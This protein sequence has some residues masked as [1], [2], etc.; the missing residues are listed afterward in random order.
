[1]AQR[2]EFS[3]EQARIQ[4]GDLLDTVHARNVR[5]TITHRGFPRAVLVGYEDMQK[6]EELEKA[7]RKPRRRA[8]R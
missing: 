5:V 8:S 7:A 4:W 6:L 1:M 3:A 2:Q